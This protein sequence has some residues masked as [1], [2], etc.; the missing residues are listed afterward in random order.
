MPAFLSSWAGRGELQEG[1]LP[2]AH[3][4]ACLLLEG[5]GYHWEGDGP[6][7]AVQVRPFQ[8]VWV[9]STKQFLVTFLYEGSA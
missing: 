2:V 8:L 3:Y 4:S 5:G 1:C 7:A 9:E 6:E